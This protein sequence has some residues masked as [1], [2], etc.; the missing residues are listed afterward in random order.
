MNSALRLYTSVPKSPDNR[1]ARILC[2]AISIGLT[3]SVLTGAYSALVFTLLQLYCKTAIGLKRDD[4][5]TF[6]FENTAPLRR[7]GF[8]CFL[9]A[10]TSFSFSFACFPLLYVKNWSRAHR[11]ERWAV[12]AVAMLATL[13]TLRDVHKMISLAGAMFKG[14]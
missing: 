8:R 7:A 12:F 14:I 11:D 5:F 2:V 3:L 4:A 1:A 6:F 13:F 10:L 9:T